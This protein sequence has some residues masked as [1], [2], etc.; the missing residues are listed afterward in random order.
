MDLV[1]SH[2]SS[3]LSAAEAVRGSMLFVT[4]INGTNHMLKVRG[5]LSALLDDALKDR[6]CCTVYS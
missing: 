1:K 3:T 6:M 5:V 2:L 4:D